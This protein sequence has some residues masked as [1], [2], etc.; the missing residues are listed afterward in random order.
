VPSTATSSTTT[1]TL[2]APAPAT[3]QAPYSVWRQPATTPLDGLGTWMATGN[4]PTPGG[5]QLP[6]SYLYAS[7]FNF[8]GSPTPGVVALTTGPSGKYAAFAVL[9]NAVPLRFAVVPFDWQAGRFYYL[10]VY[11][12]APGTWGGWVVDYSA[13]TWTP[14]GVL[15]VPSSWGKL[16]PNASTMAAWSGP[17]AATCARYPRADV[18]VAPPVGYGP[19]GTTIATSGGGNPLTPGT[20]PA[21]NTTEAGGWSHYG[22]GVG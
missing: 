13:G 3:P 7:V 4:D 20:C 9:D 6:A 19:G 14:I 8:T 22:L 11:Q 2:P 21:Q 10:L 16:T 18:F 5:G 1:T 15:N 12:L 17:T